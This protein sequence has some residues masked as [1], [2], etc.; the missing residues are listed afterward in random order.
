M[1]ELS[2]LTE[3]SRTVTAD[4]FIRL[5]EEA[6]D[7]LREER[8]RGRAGRHSIEGGL[9]NVA[10]SDLAV[11]S[12]IHGDLESL[13]FILHD[14][15][16]F[17]EDRTLLFLGDYGDRGTH[18]PE[19]YYETLWL[20]ANFPERIL[21][22]R[23]N[24]E[25]PED[26]MAMPHDLPHHTDMRFGD[27]GG[28]VYN[29][30]QELFDLLLHAALIE[31]RYLLLHG[32]IPGNIESLH[33]LAHADETHPKTSLLQEILWNDPVDELL[34]VYPNPRGA[35][36]LFGEDVTDRTL[37]ILGVKTLIRG[38]QPCHNGVNVNHSGMVLTL[39]SRK[40]PP[41][42]NRWGAYLKLGTRENP[43]DAYTLARTATRF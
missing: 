43:A 2:R 42:L 34:G 33:E 7:K 24:H 9:V 4:E 18:S 20:K 22:L 32:G 19:V 14:S 23:G 6:G 30:L 10:P 13:E 27:D 36:N 21:L 3:A 31:D 12:D 41:Y 28:R 5:I 11:I 8:A 40:G 39:F 38:H 29:S 37:N 15:G 17:E 35:G 26:L 1:D 16:F 25:G